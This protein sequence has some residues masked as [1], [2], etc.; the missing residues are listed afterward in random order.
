MQHRSTIAVFSEWQR[1]ALGQ[2]IGFRAP[3][4][5]AIAPRRI[6]R[7]LADIFFL[8]SNQIG[9]TVFRLAGTQIC[10]L[11]G[12][13]LKHTSL[14]SLWSENS[15]TALVEMM[16]KVHALQVPALS[17]HHGISLS[18]RQVP[19]EMMLAP[20]KTSQAGKTEYVGSL[21]VLETFSWIGVDPI[22]FAHLRSIH[23]VAPD[24]TKSTKQKLLPIP[25][26]IAQ[27]VNASTSYNNWNK[28]TK[29]QAAPRLRLI[30]G[31][32]I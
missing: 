30:A 19:L 26:D 24:S 20:L 32:K 17:Y 7:H 1:L 28:Q 4:R 14:Q 5:K 11:Y 6:G 2:N 27:C 18:G 3:Q 21:V 15:R 10:T 31:G 25:Q 12:R 23:P 13:E 8:E 22:V 29:N 16:K 9:E